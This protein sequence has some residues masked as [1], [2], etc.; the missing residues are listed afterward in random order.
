MSD[1][2][3]RHQ[4]EV[5]ATMI[6]MRAFEERNPGAGE[7][8]AYAYADRYWRQY[9]EQAID[10]IAFRMVDAELSAAAPWN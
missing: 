1:D 10:F 6:A 8:A 3:L 4:V 9:V 5:A 7:D 2:E